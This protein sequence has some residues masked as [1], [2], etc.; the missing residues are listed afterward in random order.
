MDQYHNQTHEFPRSW[1][2]TITKGFLGGD[3]PTG[4]LETRHYPKV[5]LENLIKKEG[6]ST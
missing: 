3:M 1:E 6:A 4:K 5:I 2:E